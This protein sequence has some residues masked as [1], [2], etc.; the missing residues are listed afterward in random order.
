MRIIN[1]NFPEIKK[2]EG[3]F[4]QMSKSSGLRVHSYIKEAF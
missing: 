3:S 2:I 1:A 4:S